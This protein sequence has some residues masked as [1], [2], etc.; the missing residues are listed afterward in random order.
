MIR[1]DL[2][3]EV[4]AKRG[5]SQRQVAKRLGITDKTFYQKMKKGVFTS[6]EIYQMIEILSIEEIKEIFFAKEVAR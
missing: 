5:T 3:L 1:T 4:I 2:L 6:N